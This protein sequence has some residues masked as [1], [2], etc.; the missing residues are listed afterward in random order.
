[1]EKKLLENRKKMIYEFM[2]SDL[3]V[4]MKIKELAILL[5][6]PREERGD[7][8]EV[9]AALVKERKIEVSKRG[10]YTKT[11]GKNLCGVFTGN[12][13]GFG[14]VTIEGEPEDIYI[15]EDHV[16]GAIH[17]DL[18]QVTLLPEKSG[19]RREGAVAQILERGMSRGQCETGAGRLYPHRTIQ[20]GGRRPQS[21]G[22]AYGLRQQ[23]AQ[24]R[25]E[26]GGNH[27]PY[28]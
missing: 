19:K 23:A 12:V 17:G 25:G 22:R 3:Y 26:S 13:R 16:N 2:C 18:V 8:E 28:Q 6:V 7:L 21:C 9:L 20:G 27:R 5:D 10:K 11:E 4:P 14:F 15:P 24:A 1:M